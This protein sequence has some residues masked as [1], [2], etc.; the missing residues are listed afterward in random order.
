MNSPLRKETVVMRSSYSFA[1]VTLTEQ[2]PNLWLCSFH[3]FLYEWNLKMHVCLAH[4]WEENQL[5]KGLFYLK[6]IYR[7]NATTIKKPNSIFQGNRRNSSKTCRK[8]NKQ[9]KKTLNV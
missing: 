1:S 5:S 8:R 3:T 9:T 2:G 6:V 4:G 7:F